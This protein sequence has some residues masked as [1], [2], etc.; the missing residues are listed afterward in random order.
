MIALIEYSTNTFGCQKW[1][2]DDLVDIYSGGDN[3]IEIEFE[4][5]EKLTPKVSAL[6]KFYAEHLPYQFGNSVTFVSNVKV[7]I[8]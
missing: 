7:T 6:K 2:S 5:E 4:T 1:Q 8:L 3:S